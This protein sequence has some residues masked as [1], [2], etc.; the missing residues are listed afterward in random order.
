M[1]IP[2][3]LLPLLATLALSFASPISP[4][5]SKG[6]GSY[7]RSS[8][9]PNTCLTVQNGYAAIGST[10]ALTN[11]V[12]IPGTYLD[13][14]QLFSPTGAQK[15]GPIKLVAHPELCLEADISNGNGGKVTV[16]SCDASR[17]GQAFSIGSVEGSKMKITIGENGS[18]CLDVVKDSAPI[19]AKPYGSIKDL[20]TW[21]CHGADH[22]D[23]AQQYF[24]LA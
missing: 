4:R 10:V 9:T 1:F 15:R 22:P 19:D 5:A 11:C 16:Q 7:F 13:E 18:Q 12:A 20:Q 24:S 2:T 14:F 17:E 21:E 23:V 3:L 8:S 6:E